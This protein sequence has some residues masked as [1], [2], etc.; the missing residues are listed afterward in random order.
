ME[1]FSAG[2]RTASDDR[3]SPV[4]SSLSEKVMMMRRKIASD[5]RLSLVMSNLSEKVHCTVSQNEER[6]WCW[7]DQSL[8]IWRPFF[9]IGAEAIDYHLSFLFKDLKCL[10]MNIRKKR[11]C[12]HEWKCTEFVFQILH[13]EPL[14]RREGGFVCLATNL[15]LQ[16]ANQRSVW[17]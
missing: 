15:C 8:E 14:K 17:E 3:L 7:L 13:N 2:R 12:E 4:M 5:D 6:E 10:S 16:T 9:F 11:N 1:L